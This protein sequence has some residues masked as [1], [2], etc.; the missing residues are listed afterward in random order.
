[1]DTLSLSGLV[2]TYSTGQ[3]MDLL[4]FSDARFSSFARRKALRTPPQPKSHRTEGVRPSF[5]TPYHDN[6]LMET[7]PGSGL[8]R[9]P[10]LD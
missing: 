10:L 3:P 9:S 8:D 4:P 6:S 7:V 2:A 5:R 1:M